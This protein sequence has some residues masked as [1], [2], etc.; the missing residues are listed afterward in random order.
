MIINSFLLSESFSYNSCLISFNIAQGV[1]FSLKIPFPTNDHC[2]F[3]QLNKISDLIID[4][5]PIGVS[6]DLFVVAS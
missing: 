2:T 4:S 6:A 3:G 1:S 5:C